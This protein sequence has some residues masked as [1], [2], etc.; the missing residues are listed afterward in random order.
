MKSILKL[1]Q[2]VGKNV[3][4]LGVIVSFIIVIAFLPTAFV[5]HS[6]DPKKPSGAPVPAVQF[7]GQWTLTDE[8]A[9][10]L[11]VDA[12]EEPI[13]YKF[14]QMDG[15][16]DIVPRHPEKMKAELTVA[17]DSLT[18]GNALRDRT[19]KGSEHFDATGFPEVSFQ[20]KEVENWPISWGEGVPMQFRLKGTLTI[21]GK[22]RDVVF[23]ADGKH[24][25]KLLRVKA[26]TDITLQDFA[27]APINGK[28]QVELILQM[29]WDKQPSWEGN[30]P[31]DDLKDG[32][33]KIAVNTTYQADVT[34]DPEKKNLQGTVA[35]QTKNDTGRPQDA[36]YFH[37]YPNQFLEPRKLTGM[38]WERMIGDDAKPG[39]ID[40]LQITVD[41]QSVPFEVNKTILKIPMN[42]Q[43]D[44]ALTLRIDFK[45]TVPKNNSRM[46]FDDH[47]MWLGNW[48][49]IR[50]VHDAQGWH[51]DPYYPIGDPFYSEVA[52]YELNVT[53]PKEY[54][55]ASSGTDQQVTEKGDMRTY[56]IDAHQMRDVALV[57]M[58]QTFR[59]T[60][61]EVD[62]V[63]VKT[64]YSYT[65]NL[66]QVQATHEAASKSLVYFSKH[67]GDYPYREF[68]VVRTGGFFGGMEYPGLVFVVDRYMK[69]RDDLMLGVVVHE[70]AHQWFYGLIG[71]NEVTEPWV[72]ESLTDYAATRWF[73]AEMPETGKKRLANQK[74]ALQ[75]TVEL[76]KNKEI[77][78]QPVT[79]FTN[80]STYSK[81]VYQKG[82]MMFYEL[83]Q[84]IG[85]EKMDLI[86]QTYFQRYQYKNATADELISIFEEELG[87]NARTYFE[88]W[89]NGSVATYAP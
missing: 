2:L 72:D 28:E 22:S 61:E 47:G 60:R 76:E 52:N 11:K 40:V 27:I 14:E 49:P 87:P 51:L 43:Q 17:V 36:L 12:P 70:T 62:G 1:L 37:L 8:S 69:Q 4:A 58:D 10:Y 3:L 57:V 19:V 48:L 73:L 89:L 7:L 32:V 83:E 13:H 15:E 86:L 81:L 45:I 26:E 55:L 44:Q 75:D 59:Q 65:D 41:G 85:Q 46:T 35:I 30:T 6:E 29:V 74:K 24:Y 23:E 84:Q 5:V 39:G 88:K 25:K 77:I 42:W 56:A 34:I 67:F 78:G 38:L 80:N 53:L 16:W 33:T 50:A 31:A 20:L 9:M 68:D 71:N 66:D 54:Q 79:G 82:A 63:V 21:K 64:W 18:S